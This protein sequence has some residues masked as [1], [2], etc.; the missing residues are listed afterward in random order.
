MTNGKTHDSTGD[1]TFSKLQAGQ[2]TAAAA[3][4]AASLPYDFLPALGPSFLSNVYFTAAIENPFGCVI[5]ANHNGKLVGLIEVT[6]NTQQYLS[7]TMR[8]H[9]LAVAGYSLLL[10]LHPRRLVEA[11]AITL[12]GRPSELPPPFGEVTLF[13]VDR[14]WRGKGLGGPLIR[15]ANAYF[16][17]QNLETAVTKTLAGNLAAIRAYAFTGAKITVRQQIRQKEYVFLQWDTSE[18][19]SS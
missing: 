14:E 12:S 13:A 8:R 11:V 3:L 16:R 17:N 2:T 18:M 5:T 9:W 1:V 10:L 7:W 15:E 19:K 6:K 4:H